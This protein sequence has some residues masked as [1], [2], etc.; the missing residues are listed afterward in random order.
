MTL[1]TFT[2]GIVFLPDD[3]TETS[4]TIENDEIVDIGGPVQGEEVC[5]AGRILAP[6]LIDVHGD[7]FERQ[8]MPRP[9]VFF[10]IE[11]AVLETDRQLASNGIATTYHSIT[12]GFE[13]G[14]RSVERGREIMEAINS[15][16][17]RLLVENRV[18]LRW[19]TFATEALDTLEWAMENPLKPSLAFNDHLSMAMRSFETPIQQRLFEHSPDFETADIDHP[20]FAQKRFAKVAA[21]T[22]VP[23]DE[24]MQLVRSVWDRRE[25]V[26][27]SIKIIGAKARAKAVP[28]LSH[29]DTQAET[30][31]FYRGVGATTTEFPMTIGPTRDARDAGDKI[32]FGSPNVVRG[33]SHIGSLSAADMVEDGLCDALASDYY[34]PAMLAAVARLDKERR[35]TRPDLWSL[36]SGGPANAMH[37]DDRGVIAV[38]KRADVVMLDWPENGTPAVVG[39]WTGGRQ[40]YRSI[41][42]G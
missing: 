24:F 22:G 26:P 4:V 30:R 14:L 7:A 31:A 3:M 6:A 28:M 8:I 23:L 20:D 25:Q 36:V 21:R 15:L 11:T 37:L 2:G 39:T 19:E 35:A 17:P 9:G 29:D 18:Q 32:I 10:P 5:A 41:A 34:Y 27:T 16:A 42:S 1:Q 38:G 13:P 33:G 40:A 12:L